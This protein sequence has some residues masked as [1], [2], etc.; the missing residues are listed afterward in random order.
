[1][2]RLVF[3]A[4]V[5]LGRQYEVLL[6]GPE[7]CEAHSRVTGGVWS[8]PLTPL[9]RFLACL[10]WKASW[11]ALRHQPD[12]VLAGSGLAAPAARAAGTLSSAPVLCYMHGLDLVAP[13]LVY[14]RL[15]IPMVRRCDVLVANSRNTAKLIA[16]HA[17]RETGIR[18]LH[19][20]V[21]LPARTPAGLTSF[22]QRLGVEGRP[23]LLSVG[24]LSARKGLAEFIESVLPR[25]VA[26]RP[27]TVLAVVG[28]APRRALHSAGGERGRV[29][30]AIER[31]RMQQHVF[32]LGTATDDVLAQA[33]D[34]SDLL[35]FP[36][37]DVPGDVEGFGMVALEAA[38][39]GLPTV[40]Y[41]VGGV[42]D[43]VSENVSGYLVA[44]EDHEAFAQVVVRHLENEQRDRWR[45]RCTAFAEAFSW[46]RFGTRLRDICADAIAQKRRERPPGGSVL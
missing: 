26:R 34:E 27:E 28:D 23:L 29:E 38:A 8:C 42:P 5:E 14:R 16:R 33:Y 21:E 6:L 22:R 4:S 30:A 11:I 43:A 45:E 20:G 24:R 41:A 1:M 25:V 37:R 46:E 35:V 17:G 9:P 7:G 36:V 3:K 19:P 44:P 31:S 10:Q 40:A 39:H 18:I 2:E 13:S 32:M 12:L 15:F